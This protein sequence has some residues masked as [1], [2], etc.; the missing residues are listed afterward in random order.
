MRWPRQGSPLHEVRMVRRY[1]A[2]CRAQ[3]R[4]WRSHLNPLGLTPL[5]VAAGW[6]SGYEPPAARAISRARTPRSVLDQLLRP[7]LARPP[8][9]VAFSG[10]RDSSAILAA[11][12]ALARREG[13]PLPVP[14]SRVFPQLPALDE[15]TWQTLVVRH[16]GL[17]DW[18]RLP[19]EDELDLIGPVAGPSLRRHGLLYPALVHSMLPMLKLAGGGTLVT[20]E[21]GDEVLGPGRGWPLR[22]LAS[23]SCPFR[24]L[25][26]PAVTS[27][28]PV[29]L[30]RVLL[31]RVLASRPLA[32]LQ[33]E[34]RSEALRSMVDDALRQP[35]FARSAVPLIIRQRGWQLGVASLG[36]L[37]ASV[38]TRV[39]HP[40]MSE[41]FVAAVGASAPQLG[42]SS[43]TEAMEK[44][45][46]DLLPDPVVQ[47]ADKAEFTSAVFHRHSRR[48]AEAWDGSGID[49]TVVDVAALRREWASERPSALTNLLLQSAWTHSNTDVPPTPS[50]SRR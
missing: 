20:G 12:V 18:T 35:L 7:A 40:L 26:R 2:C 48:F 34:A 3:R 14:V 44:L 47:R 22:Q 5:E 1:N 19:V 4:S 11:A 25:L 17:R 6:V 16:L 32:W 23:R 29:T 27:L 33:P 30:R 39:L 15:T 24:R 50:Q 10:G 21:G 13:L 31:R 41:Q 46:G 36:R 43:R 8:C 49:E 38:Q 9:L 42:F 45:F 28:A 37:G